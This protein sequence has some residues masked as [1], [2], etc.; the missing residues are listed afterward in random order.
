MVEILFPAVL[1]GLGLSSVMG[2][3]TL[4]KMETEMDLATIV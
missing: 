3:F 1:N 4:A 2:N